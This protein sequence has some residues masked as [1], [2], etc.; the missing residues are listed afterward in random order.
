MGRI[1][2]F[3][4]PNSPWWI[5]KNPTHVDRVGHMSW[6]FFLITTII[7]IKLSIRTTLAQLRANL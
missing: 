3:F 1:E 5:K 6:I 7:I 4:Q 2:R